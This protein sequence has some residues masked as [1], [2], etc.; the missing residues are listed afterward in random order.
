VG[1]YVRKSVKAGPFRFNLSKSGIGVSTGVPGFRIST[2]P[3]GNH[4]SI[5]S[6]GVYYRTTLGGGRRRTSAARGPRR[7]VSG[8]ARSPRAVRVQPVDEVVLQDTQGAGVDRL[9]PSGGGDLVG[10]LNTAAARSFPWTLLLV[11]VLV[12]AAAAGRVGVVIA[13]LA[14]PAVVWLALRARARRKVV[15]LYEVDGPPAQWFQ[16]VVD[17]FE[18]MAGAA[19]A[20]RLTGAGEVVGTRAYKTH[21]GVAL[22]VRQVAATITTAGPPHLATNVAVPTVSTG[23]DSLHFLPDRVLVRT[24]RRY[25]DVAYAQL[26]VRS[27]SVSFVEAG[28]VPRDAQRVGTRWQYTNLKGGPDHRYKNNR[29]LPVLLYGRLTLASSNGLNWVID[30]SQVAPVR[31]AQTALQQVPAATL[32]RTGPPAG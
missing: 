32:A 27:E 8:A 19:K 21:A 23:P 13:V 25:T 9:V 14:I 10:Q 30:L 17:A 6:H 28:A 15:A 2:G 18:T 26:S 22:E 16:Q 11:A 7:A 20:W 24:G 3:R 12:V 5:G 1:F 31:A 29:E 4:V